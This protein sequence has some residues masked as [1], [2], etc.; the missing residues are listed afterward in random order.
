MKQVDQALFIELSGKRLV[1]MTGCAHTGVVNTV[2]HAERL[3]PGHSIFA[4][5]GGL[6]LNNADEEQ[7]SETLECLHQTDLKYVAE[8]H[9]TG[10]FAQ[11]VLMDRFADR[12]I[13]TAPQKRFCSFGV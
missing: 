4:V 1:V 5:L 13:A 6:H 10:Y 3:F 8:F 12:R 7:M 11:K 2:M 9:C